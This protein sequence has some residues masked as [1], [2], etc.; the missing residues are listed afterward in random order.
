[1]FEIICWHWFF[2]RIVYEQILAFGTLEDIIHSG[3]SNQFI[4]IGLLCQQLCIE[5]LTHSRAAFCVTISVVSASDKQRNF[6]GVC[7]YVFIFIFALYGCYSLQFVHNKGSRMLNY[8]YLVLQYFGF[9]MRN[10][11]F[12]LN[13]LQL[14]ICGCSWTVEW[15][16][17]LA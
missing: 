13:R 4:A 15:Q 12:V 8:L 14:K 1:M 9:V 2:V 11:K 3:R 5:L 6:G 7:I 16:C 17:Y 10:P